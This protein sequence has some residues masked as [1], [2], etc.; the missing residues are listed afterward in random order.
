MPATNPEWG[1][2]ELPIEGLLDVEAW[3]L[4][5]AERLLTAPRVPLAARRCWPGDTAV[6]AL[7]LRR[8]LPPY[9]GAAGQGALPVYVG[10]NRQMPLGHGTAGLGPGPRYPSRGGMNNR[11]RPMRWQLRHARGLACEDLA[12]A[13]LLGPPFLALQVEDAAIRA[14]RPVWN[15]ALRGFARFRARKVLTDP[16]HL[17]HCP[18][19]GADQA[20]VDRLSREVAAYCAAQSPPV[21]AGARGTPRGPRSGRTS[22]AGSSSVPPRRPANPDWEALVLPGMP[23]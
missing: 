3:A 21:L 10:A 4:S 18:E 7:F 2:I 14:F 16:W 8:P 19:G 22:G 15:L 5:Q 23:T 17:L 1:N 9:G 6:Y 20:T 11:L 12:L 13:L